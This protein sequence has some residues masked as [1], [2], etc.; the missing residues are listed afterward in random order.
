MLTN[1]SKN[2]KYDISQKLI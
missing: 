1:F 2:P